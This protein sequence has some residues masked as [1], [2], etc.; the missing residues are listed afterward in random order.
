MNTSLNCSC[1][2]KDAT[3]TTRLTCLAGPLTSWHSTYY[4]SCKTPQ[5]L[6]N[7]GWL[8]RVVTTACDGPSARGNKEL[9]ELIMEEGVPLVDTR[10][11]HIILESINANITSA[12]HKETYAAFVW[13]VFDRFGYQGL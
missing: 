12:L 3:P 8:R 9:R 10:C 6:T 1:L 11:A 5:V 13:A 4:P 7:H 2:R